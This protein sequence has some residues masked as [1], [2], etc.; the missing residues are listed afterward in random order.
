MVLC[1]HYFWD[2]ADLH[3]MLDGVIW[4]SQSSS[5]KVQSFRSANCT[6]GVTVLDNKYK[7]NF[8]LVVTF[9]RMCKRNEVPLRLGCYVMWKF[10]IS[11]ENNCIVLTVWIMHFEWPCH[12]HDA[13]ICNGPTDPVFVSTSKTSLMDTLSSSKLFS[14]LQLYF[15]QDSS[16]SNLKSSP[17]ISC[18]C[19]T[20]IEWSLPFFFNFPLPHRLQVTKVLL[21]NS[22]STMPTTWH[23]HNM[24]IHASQN[25]IKCSGGEK[26][27]VKTGIQRTD[28][29]CCN[30][31]SIENDFTKTSKPQS[32]FI[33]LPPTLQ[34]Y[35]IALIV[36]LNIL[37]SNCVLIGA[38]ARVPNMNLNEP[39]SNE[40]IHNLLTSLICDQIPT[41]ILFSQDEIQSC[42]QSRCYLSSESPCC[43]HPHKNNLTNLCHAE[44]CNLTH[45][46]TCC[47]AIERVSNADNQASQY[48]RMFSET[49]SKYTTPET[50]SRRWSLD[51]CIVRTNASYAQ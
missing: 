47:E 35:D 15:P 32:P 20:I 13:Y 21:S 1:L 50:Y 12:W 28:I 4:T 31:E 18:Y 39:S 46:Q 48:A 41:N 36:I 45:S 33:S 3:V 40:S 29:I 30:V 11:R 22:S 7:N 43:S 2:I 24:N 16:L 19:I 42:H 8:K 5:Q 23:K 26:S 6:W 10:W 9:R 37:I 27:S 49:M 38:H 34:R 51:H 17:E 14:E 44:G 25:S